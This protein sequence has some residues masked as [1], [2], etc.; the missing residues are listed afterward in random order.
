MSD[1]IIGKVRNSAGK[2]YEVKWND[3]GEVYVRE[4]G[5]WG[6]TWDGPRQKA[7]SAGEAMRIAE[8]FV[9]NK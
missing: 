9:Y 5:G 4:I 7:S 8:A 2:E 3:W 6:S 1:S